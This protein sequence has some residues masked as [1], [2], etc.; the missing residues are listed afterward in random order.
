M[1]VKIGGK[2]HNIKKGDVIQAT[3]EGSK[4]FVG[5]DRVSKSG[6]RGIFTQVEVPRGARGMSATE[7]RGDIMSGDRAALSKKLPPNWN[8]FISSNL[9]D[10]QRQQGMMAG[11]EAKK[12]A[13]I[14]EEKA[15]LWGKM[16]VPY[17]PYG[18]NP[19]LNKKRVAEYPKETAMIAELN[20]ASKK[21]VSHK[22]RKRVFPN[23]AEGY[24]PNFRTSSMNDALKRS[25]IAET[26]AG[27]GN[28]RF[29]LD[30]RLTA[31]G[32]P[33]GIGTYNTSEGSLSKAIAM[34]RGSGVNVQ[35]LRSL[36]KDQQR[37]SG[38]IIPNFADPVSVWKS[39]ERFLL[40]NSGETATTGTGAFGK[41]TRKM[42]RMEVWS[43]DRQ[44][45]KEAKATAKELGGAGGGA[46]SLGMGLM[47]GGP[48]A[49]TMG[50]RVLEQQGVIGGRL[51][52]QTAGGV[53]GATTGGMLAAF[54]PGMSKLPKKISIPIGIAITAFSAV[55][56]K[57][58]GEFEYDMKELSL[59]AQKTLADFQ[60]MSNASAKYIESTE[61]F[62]SAITDSK[63][64]ARTLARLSRESNKQLALLS[65]NVRAKIAQGVSP[66][67]RREIVMGAVTTG[68]GKAE[69]AGIGARLSQ[70]KLLGKEA[71]GKQGWLGILG[72]PDLERESVD[73][74]AT[75]GKAIAFGL[76]DFDKMVKAF[77]KGG[78][79]ALGQFGFSRGPT[80][81]AGIDKLQ[82]KGVL[83]ETLA[84]RMKEALEAG[85]NQTVDII[86]TS[87][88]EVIKLE[89]ETRKIM[90]QITIAKE[91]ENKQLNKL[92]KGF[93]EF[94]M[95][96]DTARKLTDMDL[97]AGARS[98]KRFLSA[99]G[100][101]NFGFESAQL[102]NFR[103][104]KNAVGTLQFNALE[105]IR[106][107]DIATP[108]GSSAQIKSLLGPQT[109]NKQFSDRLTQQ[110][111]QLNRTPE[112]AKINNDIL[113]ALIS[114]RDKTDSSLNEQKQQ[115]EVNKK[116]RDL[117][118]QEA[119]EQ[120]NLAIG[121]G[122]ESFMNPDSMNA[123][124]DKLSKASMQQRLGIGGGRGFVNQSAVAQEL[125][126]G[127][128]GSAK[129]ITT[130][131]TAET[132]IPQ[133]RKELLT[134]AR[135]IQMNSRF[136]GGSQRQASLAQATELRKLANDPAR[137]M[138]SM[139]QQAAD[140][141]NVDTLRDGVAGGLD[142]S[143]VGKAWLS[144]LPAQARA[145]SL[146]PF[147][148]G[149]KVREIR[150]AEK[151]AQQRQA[152]S[153]VEGSIKHFTD[154]LEDLAEAMKKAIDKVGGLD[155]EGSRRGFIPSFNLNRRREMGQAGVSRAQTYQWNVP[156]FGPAIGNRKDEPSMS[157]LQ[158]AVMSHSN[159]RFAGASGGFVPSF[160]RVRHEG[161]RRGGRAAANRFKDP[162]PG[163]AR[164]A[165]QAGWTAVPSTT[166]VDGIRSGG[167][168]FEKIPPAVSPKS[169]A[170]S[171]SNVKDV[172]KQPNPFGDF[173]GNV[174]T[175]ERVRKGYRKT[176]T[177]RTGSGDSGGTYK[178]QAMKG[179]PMHRDDYIARQV[180]KMT[181]RGD[182][183]AKITAAMPRLLKELAVIK[184]IEAK[185]RANA[186][187]RSSAMVPLKGPT[188]VRIQ[189]DGKSVA[190]DPGKVAGAKIQGKTTTMNVPGSSKG[191]DPK[192]IKVT[193]GTRAVGM[194]GTAP[195]NATWTYSDGNISRILSQKQAMDIYK[196]AGYDMGKPTTRGGIQQNYQPGRAAMPT[197]QAGYTTMSDMSG[198]APAQGR[199]LG[200]Q[201]D[202]IGPTKSTR[203]PGIR[204][205][206][207]LAHHAATV[208]D[209]GSG[210]SRTSGAAA[211][212]S[213]VSG[214]KAGWSKFSESGWRHPLQTTQR[215]FGRGWDATV[216]KPG[217]GGAPNRWTRQRSLPK[218]ISN[219]GGMRNTLGEAFL[220]KQKGQRSWGKTIAKDSWRRAASRGMGEIGRGFTRTPTPA[221]ASMGT[222]MLRGTGRLGS[223]ALWFLTPI[224]EDAMLKGSAK[225]KRTE[226]M[227]LLSTGQISAEQYDY[228]AKMAISGKNFKTEMGMATMEEDVR[229]GV[230]GA[231]TGLAVGLGAAALAA[232]ATGIGL[233]VGILLGIAA[234]A[235]GYM[236][237]DWGGRNLAGESEWSKDW[238]KDYMKDMS[239]AERKKLAKL[240]SR[241][242]KIRG[243][244]E[245]QGLSAPQIMK[246]GTFGPNQQ[247]FD[248]ELLKRESARDAGVGG[249]YSK[250]PYLST[251]K[252]A[253]KSKLL[254]VRKTR[255]EWFQ[256]GDANTLKKE[257]M[258]EIRETVM[259]QLNKESYGRGR[260]KKMPKNAK[261]GSRQ[262][263]KITEHND[264]IIS[265]INN[266]RAKLIQDIRFGLEGHIGL[267][268]NGNQISLDNL[269]EELLKK[270][271][272][273][274]KTEDTEG[275]PKKPT[276]HDIKAVREFNRRYG[277][278]WG[279]GKHG[280]VKAPTT[281]AEVDALLEK[282]K[283]FQD[284]F[285]ELESQG[286][287]PRMFTKFGSRNEEGKPMPRSARRQA[288]IRNKM[289]TRIERKGEDDQLFE[290]TTTPQD[291][292]DEQARKEA[293]RRKRIGDINKNGY[294]EGGRW[295]IPGVGSRPVRDSDPYRKKPQRYSGGFVPNF[296]AAAMELNNSY[297]RAS[298]R[299][300]SLRGIGLANTEETLGHHPRFT[301]PFVNPPEGSREGMLHKMRSVSRTGVNP[302]MIPN[303][304]LSSQGSI[305]EIDTSN[306]QSSLGA[307]TQEFD[308]LKIVLAQGGFIPDGSGSGTSTVTNNMS[309]YSSGAQSA[310]GTVDPDLGAKIETVIN[311]VKR[312]LPKEYARASMPAR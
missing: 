206:A 277:D 46:S 305:P 115:T 221:G 95:G 77:G 1:V 257:K 274:K 299:V 287:L 193:W 268:Q 22:W 74:L 248:A 308:N 219:M 132:M 223:K 65:P 62:E 224:I 116:I 32:N 173:Y 181:L 301:Q 283:M 167:F 226:L 13:V 70:E 31:S 69:Q 96:Q 93:E 187:V 162:K 295:V 36:G 123:R 188:E 254:G 222:K 232:S 209:Y 18:R 16:G 216:A 54:M 208:S 285:G 198:K 82:E 241:S 171:V 19:A 270:F 161:Q 163:S 55:V 250:D 9:G 252:D 108:S 139:T 240:K 184:K 134:A 47:F 91:R 151:E 168:T 260:I 23:L 26:A 196:N 4:L 68:Q 307:L 59:A 201:R 51:A 259:A 83:E 186:L 101:A 263:K 17:D 94:K 33:L 166:K 165:T 35:E 99:R 11:R 128:L 195:G 282:R 10:I 90:E 217:A 213:K 269:D 133:R 150:Q 278:D 175:E 52:A 39:M 104:S 288:W 2:T 234:G 142:N 130:R 89:S 118:I 306:A 170:G 245:K 225:E 45:R 57:T 256:K 177:P 42:T 15:R 98:G 304:S 27:Q 276:K 48:M 238:A 147:Q 298:T 266:A 86:I 280:G 152:R 281:A 271:N 203:A 124:F 158:M 235:V 258:D 7:V 249:W 121:G 78:E 290:E 159:P 284:Q 76:K 140:F 214:I 126:G 230:A 30:P 178:S 109:I 107:G 309:V 302:Y 64:T 157:A 180:R 72:P 218:F 56:G 262:W 296:S 29:G 49:A 279:L 212:E 5:S 125:L 97:K 37:A 243:G 85:A 220:G 24:V 40:N 297:S 141:F 127:D 106:T 194:P 92:R 154:K 145:D 267:D 312:G 100:Q 197:G 244:L 156:G 111:N 303:T 169:T 20:A 291:I 149:V 114:I 112:D 80:T 253:E 160:A 129:G 207:P 3:A 190:G 28:V 67:E 131:A 294:R 63:V 14:N 300:V 84:S 43:S 311:A 38:G 261:Y 61:A 137:L 233:P 143:Q 136:Q 293:G 34:H 135:V 146:Q 172:L 153:D 6:I 53:E 227:K 247:Q 275:Q 199:A 8:K 272:V 79:G 113:T 58:S 12:L 119:R 215:A 229:G 251:L 228:F 255:D 148:R 200:L 205:S 192:N 88:K 189:M 21:A 102:E 211:A 264:L 202:F 120:Q 155:E 75:E 191:L 41:G 110:I 289:G 105:G 231:A 239:P 183:Q 50:I 138:E 60:K 236:A 237:G 179:N 182:S 73:K 185:I 117:Q 310:G 87:M 210:A 204:G 164:Y 286:R 122:I 174:E 81:V 103:K 66:E 273:R 242:S 44:I 176:K 25:A 246:Q 71:L 144:A 265:N 292:M